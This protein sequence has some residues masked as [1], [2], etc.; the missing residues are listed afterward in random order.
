MS[1]ETMQTLS[2]PRSRRIGRSLQG[3]ILRNFLLVVVI[4][5]GILT[6]V[7]FV[8]AFSETQLA[9]NSRLELVAILKQQQIE[10]WVDERGADVAIVAVNPVLVNNLQVL[11]EQKPTGS[12]YRQAYSDLSIQLTDVLRRK[13]A[14]TELFLIDPNTGS[15][16]VSTDLLREGDLHRDT[17]YF[18]QGKLGLYYDSSSSND[19]QVA[20]SAFLISTPV[21]DPETGELLAVL[22][23]RANLL[24]LGAIINELGGLEETS[25][26]YLVDLEQKIVSGS[27]L[28]NTPGQ[29]VQSAGIKTVLNRQ[30]GVATYAN[31]AGV[32]VTGAYHWLPRLGLGLLVEQE[33]W[34]L[35]QPAWQSLFRNLGITGLALLPVIGLG[36]VLSR[37][38]AG[39][40]TSLTQIATA[41]AGGNL[42]Q[43]LQIN[44]D[45]EI[46]DLARAFGSMTGQLKTLIHGLE[47]QMEARS[48]RLETVAVLGERVSAILNL[49][50]LLAEVVNQ[51]Q[52]NFDYYHA[53]IY[54]FDDSGE[55]LVVAEGTGT[56]GAELKA[57]KHSISLDAPTNLV[58]RAARTGEIV[59]VDNVRLAADW[60][61]NPLLPRTWS[62][63]AV[64]I[65]LEGQAVGVLD[66]QEDKIAGLDENDANLLRSLA[67]QVAVAIRNA[68][69][70]AEVETAL[71]DAY[72]AQERYT[73]QAWEKR[74]IA[75]KR[76]QYHFADPTA[77]QLNET[78]LAKTRQQALLQN[79]L[80]LV[81]IAENGPVENPEVTVTA[82]D[83]A[84]KATAIAAPIILHNQ[85]IGTLQLFPNRADQTWT[86]DD[87]AITEAVINQ[88]VQTA[89][90]LRLFEETRER[91]GREQTIREITEKMRA[92]TT[93]EELVRTTT[94]EL[95]QHFSAEYAMA[96]LGLKRPSAHRPEEGNGYAK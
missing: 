14:F 38:I 66:V 32:E 30:N 5:S 90:N 20:A 4:L 27:R 3:L 81:P 48:R 69:L 23:A 28:R 76:G 46:G 61:P 21:L 50:E 13:L 58:A 86:E 33:Q 52:Q 49:P 51:I 53:H 59:R 40:L 26:T 70:F 11:R 7:G 87:V 18:E 35:M 75:A 93:L 25:E 89:E 55:N 12:T 15:T 2:A 79:G 1:I 72:A 80:S 6:G 44:R 74:K 36:I 82:T 94:R 57:R 65:L 9:A 31:Y 68:R 71:A 39:P 84:K 37:V 54:L 24:D 45:D 77:P 88:L 8:T 78:T 47:E 16:L 43:Q 67:N 10:R 19:S 95:G 29:Q 42:D 17:L 63:M 22:V 91:A 64:P 34:A 85:T 92:A 62:E 41:I 96:G 60:L 83:A 73:E 56:A